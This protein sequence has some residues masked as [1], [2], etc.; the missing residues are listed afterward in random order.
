MIQQQ[1]SLTEMVNQSIAVFKDPSESTFER[2]ER[3]GTFTSAA[4]YVG[5]AAVIAG[6][7]GIVGGWNGFISGILNTVVG[8]FLFTGLVY[9][10]GT[11]QGGTG[12]FD[13][14]TYT[15]SLFIAPLSLVV[16]VVLLFTI[17]PLIGLIFWPIWFVALV[18]VAVAQGFFG[19]LAVRSSM[20][21]TDQTK[22]IVTFGGAIL[23]TLIIQFLLTT[24]LY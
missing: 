15:F 11:S 21:L 4:L 17:I 9:F 12:T 16:P 3:R 8:F 2:F 10:I 5:I 19:Y 20:N 18:G 6:L 22:A 23:G 7:L 1:T 14:V 24:A 13:E